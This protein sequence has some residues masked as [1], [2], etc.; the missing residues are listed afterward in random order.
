MMRLTAAATTALILAGGELFSPDS[1]AG[2]VSELT[3]QRTG[4]TVAFQR[5][6]SETDAAKARVNELLELTADP[7]GR[8]RSCAA[9]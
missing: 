2:K 3:K 8:R 4:Q 9:Q 6:A 7:G 5:T 1:G